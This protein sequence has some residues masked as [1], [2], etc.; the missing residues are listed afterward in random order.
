MVLQGALGG[1]VG[2]KARRAQGGGA[3]AAVRGALRVG[4]GGLRYIA[5]GA[6]LSRIR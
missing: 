6:R 1:R 2:T 5:L 3:S 4:V